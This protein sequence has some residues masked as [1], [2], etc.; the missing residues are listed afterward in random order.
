MPGPVR[1]TELAMA[2]GAWRVS[3]AVPDADLVGLVEEYWEVEGTLN[4]FRETLLPNG[5]VEVMV[6]LGPSHRVVDDAGSTTWDRAWF[7]GLQEHSLIIES[8]NG[9]HLVSARLHPLGAAELLGQTVASVAN[10]IVDL[11]V[12]VGQAAEELRGRLLAASS[13][14]ARFALLE[15]FLRERRATGQPSPH[16][17]R[18]AATRIELAHG[19]VRVATLHAELGISRK[20]LAVSFTRAFGLSAKTYAMI[21]RFVWTLQRLR[22]S[23][24]VDW[25][26]LAAEAGYSDQSHLVREFRRIGAAS[27]TDYLRRWSPDGT[28]LVYELE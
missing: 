5:F 21:Q 3:S 1:E 9:T 28:A 2:M 11:E 4:A 14:A 12:L 13:P 8:L 27:P 7:S 18:E 25:T 10:S 22:E 15:T 24:A 17:V 19:T 6:N 23:T 20:H 16:F 26:K